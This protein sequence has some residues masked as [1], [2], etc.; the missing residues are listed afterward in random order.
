MVSDPHETGNAVGFIFRHSLQMEVFECWECGIPFA[1]PSHWARER[2]KQDDDGEITCP[3]GHKFR[4]VWRSETTA[5]KL[6]EEN[7][8]LR[9]EL[10]QEKHNAE[11]AEG[12]RAE[13]KTI[14]EPVLEPEPQP[15]DGRIHCPKCA[16]SYKPGCKW[17]GWMRRHLMR[18][19][20]LSGEQVEETIEA[21][22]LDRCRRKMADKG[23]VP[24]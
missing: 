16:K 9:R 3:N 18:E 14:I 17:W 21:I 22:R 20:K 11:Q 6:K 15:D 10:L 23:Q 19:H 2:F 8:E 24:Q 4:C 5:E 7:E 13:G 12:R 1:V